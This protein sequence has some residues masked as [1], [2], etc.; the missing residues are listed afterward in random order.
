MGTGD[1]IV[2]RGRE[3]EPKADL[4]E[5]LGR[6]WNVADVTFREREIFS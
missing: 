6:M 4:I 3:R 1:G 2:R 5:S